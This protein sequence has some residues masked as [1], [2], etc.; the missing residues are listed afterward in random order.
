MECWTVG[1]LEIRAEEIDSMD[2][3]SSKP[4]LH[5]SIT[6]ILPPGRRPYGP[7]PSDGAKRSQVYG[8]T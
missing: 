8:K 7:E 1:M 5:H 3:N 2:R 6:P 4:I